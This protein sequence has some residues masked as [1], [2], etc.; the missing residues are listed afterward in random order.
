MRAAISQVEPGKMNDAA[1]LDIFEASQKAVPNTVLSRQ[2]AKL[3]ST[4]SPCARIKALLFSDLSRARFPRIASR[5]S[6]IPCQRKR[7]CALLL[8]R[9]QQGS[10]KMHQDFPGAKQ[11]QLERIVRQLACTHA[12]EKAC[13]TLSVA[14]CHLRILW[15]LPVLA[16]PI[17]KRLLSPNG[18]SISNF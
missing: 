8:I 6:I 4:R 11:R 17:Q 10:G 15:L 5:A 1:L 2:R 13:R 16:G 12:N 14:G 7:P 3:R 9:L 18:S